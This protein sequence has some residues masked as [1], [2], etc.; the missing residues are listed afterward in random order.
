M[1]NLLLKY[2]EFTFEGFKFSIDYNLFEWNS[3]K[4]M[5]VYMDNLLDKTDEISK[6]KY[7]RLLKLHL[8]EN[9]HIKLTYSNVFRLV[10]RLFL[11]LSIIMVF[12]KSMIVPL[13]FVSIGLLCEI[14]SNI[15]FRKVKDFYFSY[16]TTDDLID[17]VFENK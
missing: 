15:L 7:K 11:I 12:S 5:G 16:K 3:E 1:F 8:L 10:S 6:N 9:L 17:L 14:L 2:N 4:E 13:I